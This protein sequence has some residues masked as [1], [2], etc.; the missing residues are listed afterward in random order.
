M[1]SSLGRTLSGTCSHTS[2]QG[3]DIVDWDDVSAASLQEQEDDIYK[4]PNRRWPPFSPSGQERIVIKMGQII[5]SNGLPCTF[6]S[7]EEILNVHPMKFVPFYFKN[8]DDVLAQTRD[9]KNVLL[10]Q[11]LFSCA[12]TAVAMIALDQNGHPDID[13]IGYGKITELDQE[14][15]WIKVAGFDPVVH[16]I[17]GNVVQKAE[18]LAEHLNNGSGILH[19]F[20]PELKGHVVVLDEV[21]LKNNSVVIRDPYHGRKITMKLVPLMNWAQETFIQ[22]RVSL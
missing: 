8:R 4:I 5:P 21:V 16:K 9:G 20:H 22:L 7:D 15:Y 6:V 18:Q 10:Q 2:S 13:S 19:I 3:T 14:L 1:V 17:Q 11:A 12:P